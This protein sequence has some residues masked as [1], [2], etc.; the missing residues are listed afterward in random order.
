ME[1]VCL[2]AATMP[3]PKLADPLAALP[4]PLEAI[5]HGEAVDGHKLCLRLQVETHL[6]CLARVHGRPSCRSCSCRSS[7]SCSL[8]SSA[9]DTS[10]A[11]ARAP[12]R[13]DLCKSSPVEAPCASSPASGASFPIASGLSEGRWPTSTHRPIVGQATALF[14]LP[15]TDFAHRTALRGR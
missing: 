5:L 6:G 12:D 13:P 9:E 1:G 3:M 10:P 7:G 2:M 8:C 4:P 14:C 11:G 15:L